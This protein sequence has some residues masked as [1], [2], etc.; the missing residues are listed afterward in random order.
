MA[1]H[2]LEFGHVM[3]GP[4]TNMAA[5]T[6]AAKTQ[7]GSNGKE[8]GNGQRKKWFPYGFH[9]MKGSV[10]L[11]KPS[12]FHVLDFEAKFSMNSIVITLGLLDVFSSDEDNDNEANDDE[13]EDDKANDD[14]NKNDGPITYRAFDATF[15]NSDGFPFVVPGGGSA[16]LATSHPSAIHIFQLWRTFIDRV[17][18]LLKICHVLTLQTRIVAASADPET[19]PAPLEAF[20]CYQRFG[21][22]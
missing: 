22:L 20:M 21:Q 16:G 3:D 9:I 15:G 7:S 5:D 2:G 11:P 19:I 4:S 10:C 13:H 14:S 12:K 6:A 18:P 1:H 17:D 8:G